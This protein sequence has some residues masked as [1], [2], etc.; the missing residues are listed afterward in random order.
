MKLNPKEAG[1]Q[2][3]NQLICVAGMGRCDIY[4]AK[5]YDTFNQGKTCTYKMMLT[6]M[7][8]YMML[9]ALSLSG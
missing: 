3:Q 9:F 6:V 4:R 8:A 5:G 7:W 2:L 1:I